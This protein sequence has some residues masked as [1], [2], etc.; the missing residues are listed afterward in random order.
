MVKRKGYV[1]GCIKIP[2]TSKTMAM[3]KGRL[4]TFNILES[5]GYEALESDA[6]MFNLEL[7]VCMLT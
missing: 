7:F 1:R 2:A 3:R 5:Q 4:S 6:E